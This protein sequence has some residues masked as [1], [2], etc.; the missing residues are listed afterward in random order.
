MDDAISYKEVASGNIEVGVHIADVSYFVRPKSLIDKEAFNRA[1]SVYLVDRTIPMLPPQLSEDLCSLRPNEDKFT[2]SAIFTINS[3][4]EVIGKRFTRG[5]IN[6]KKRFTYDD[7]DKALKEG[8]YH[9]V[10]SRLWEIA[11]NI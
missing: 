2:F 1:T 5:I 7:A 11:S 4:S 10:F 9:D 3:N 8:E 6:S